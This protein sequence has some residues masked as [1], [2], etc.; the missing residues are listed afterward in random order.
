MV[1]AM[2]HAKTILVTFPGCDCKS[3]DSDLFDPLYPCG[4]HILDLSQPYGQMV[5]EELL[6]IADY[7]CFIYS[8]YIFISF[9]LYYIN[10]FIYLKL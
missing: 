1:A 8:I 6:Y 5:A 4:Q 9:F 7:V 3:E 2:E 10:F